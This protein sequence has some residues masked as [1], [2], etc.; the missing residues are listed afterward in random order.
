MRGVMSSGGGLELRVCLA[1]GSLVA[2]C[3]SSATRAIEGPFR[4]CRVDVDYRGDRA[5]PHRTR[6]RPSRD[7]WSRSCVT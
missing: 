2:R 4:I 1:G 3:K 6:M 5:I 7:T